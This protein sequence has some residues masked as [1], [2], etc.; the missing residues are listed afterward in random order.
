MGSREWGVGSG[1]WG[2]R[3]DFD[4]SRNLSHPA[5]LP[6]HT[7]SWKFSPTSFLE[8]FISPPHSQYCLGFE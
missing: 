2:V 5:K 1:E 8:M 6:C 3:K 4:D 7:T